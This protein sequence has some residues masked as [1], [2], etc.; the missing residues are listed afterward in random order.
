MDLPLDLVVQSE[1]LVRSK[2]IKP[3]RLYILFGAS[4]IQKRTACWKGQPRSSQRAQYGTWSTVTSAV[5]IWQ[6]KRCC[7]CTS[8]WQARRNSATYPLIPTSFTRLIT[9]ARIYEKTSF[10]IFPNTCPLTTKKVTVE[11]LRV[12]DKKCL[13]HESRQSH[14][15]P[16]D[17][18]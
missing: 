15:V 8:D 10:R 1:Y 16:R 12:L 6:K 4:V 2:S 7:E 18:S 13:Q 9:R 14:W 17:D 11:K 5:S 3:K